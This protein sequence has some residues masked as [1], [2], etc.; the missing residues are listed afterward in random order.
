MSGGVAVG[1]QLLT[2]ECPAHAG[3]ADPYAA[4][5][6][7]SDMPRSSASMRSCRL[8]LGVTPVASSRREMV[9]G[10]QLSRVI[11]SQGGPKNQWLL[12]QYLTLLLPLEQRHTLRQDRAAP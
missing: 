2:V 4:A 3:H 6:S 11:D 5:I 12:S 1:R 10:E 7:G 9:E 8:M